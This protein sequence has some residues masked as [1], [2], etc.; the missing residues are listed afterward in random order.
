MSKSNLS[1][2]L[3]FIITSI[4]LGLSATYLSAQEK[5]TIKEKID[6]LKGEPKSITIETDKDK[7]VLKGDEA[8]VLL[9]ILNEKKQFV[10]EDEFSFSPD[11]LNKKMFV[12][13]KGKFP[14]RDF[15]WIDANEKD[16]NKEI[17]VE[18]KDGNVTVTIKTTE[19][20]KENVEVL[21]GEDAE[22]FLEKEKQA[23]R[24]RIK[25]IPRPEMRWNGCC[26]CRDR[27]DEMIFLGDEPSIE[28]FEDADVLMMDGDMKKDFKKVTVNDD[29][30]EKVVTVETNESGKKTVQTFKGKEADEYLKQLEKDG[31]M[32]IDEDMKDG[33]K[34]KKVIIKK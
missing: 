29:S 17:E 18:K 31:K 8:K 11:S 27:D 1:S 30:G 33:K 25:R 4:L 21:T 32:K 16:D 9:K 22:K 26:C 13:R 7:V 19:D 5:N 12:M 10:F 34:V 2:K 3:F 6:K 14:P 23:Q 15:F 20:G 28:F 24:F